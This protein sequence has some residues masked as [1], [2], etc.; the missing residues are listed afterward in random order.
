[1]SAL[2]D[3]TAISFTATAKAAA[4]AKGEDLIVL[5]T[6]AESHITELS[7]LLKQIV[8]IHP[9]TGGDAANYAALNAIVAELA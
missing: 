5:V 2:T 4:S 8:A 1:M 7:A 6:L 3:L 9:S